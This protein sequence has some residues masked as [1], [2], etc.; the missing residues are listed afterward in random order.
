M[1]LSPS[2]GRRGVRHRGTKMQKGLGSVE[3]VSHSKDM[4]LIRVIN[5][6]EVMLAAV[7]YSL[8]VHL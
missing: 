3:S 8:G 5:K 6:N 1:E 2:E 4:Y 7:V